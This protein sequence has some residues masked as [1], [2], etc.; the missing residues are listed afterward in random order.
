MVGSDT[1]EGNIKFDTY[2][3]TMNNKLAQGKGIPTLRLTKGSDS[4]DYGE[5]SDSTIFG[6]IHAK[7]FLNQFIVQVYESYITPSGRGGI[8]STKDGKCIVAPAT[9][10]TEALAILKR[11]SHQRLPSYEYWL[12]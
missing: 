8:W 12:E 5:W 3:L 1:F 2:P 10:R 11:I 9:N 6:Y 7:P 4:L